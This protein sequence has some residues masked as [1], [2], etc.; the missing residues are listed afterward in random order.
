MAVRK[1]HFGCYLFI[2]STIITVNCQTETECG[3]MRGPVPTQFR[4]IGGGPARIGNYPWQVSI[5]RNN[6]LICGGSII[7][8]SYVLTSAHCFR[9]RGR[10]TLY[11]GTQL[12]NNQFREGA[13]HRIV[14]IRRHPQFISQIM[15]ADVALVRVLPRFNFRPGTNGGRNAIGPICLPVARAPVTERTGIISGYGWSNFYRV[16]PYLKAARIQILNHVYCERVYRIRYRYDRNSM[17][18]AGYVN[19]GTDSCLGDSGGPLAVLTNNRVTQIGITS[20]GYGCARRG[21][22]GVYMQVSV[23]RNWIQSVALV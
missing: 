13:L 6:V 15:F 17:V 1:Q 23:F 7:S 22:P 21:Y 10:Y 16:E 20:F 14:D 5:R 9:V 2:L 12:R 18:C 3:V 19:G 4:I 11:A 8:N